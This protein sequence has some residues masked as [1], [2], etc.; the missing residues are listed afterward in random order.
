MSV[1]SVFKAFFE[2]QKS[3]TDAFRQ[4]KWDEAW[5]INMAAWDAARQQL[6][7]LD[8]RIDT[9]KA[10]RQG[11]RPNTAE[12]RDGENALQQLI[13]QRESAIQDSNHC[14]DRAV[15]LSKAQRQEHARLFGID[16]ND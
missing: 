3:S 2:P 6:K 4:A 8:S 15:A 10:S 11:W 1:E 14:A 7:E 13:K 16:G 9:V 12:R 5:E